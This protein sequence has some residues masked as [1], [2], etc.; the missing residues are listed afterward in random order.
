MADKLPKEAVRL[1]S[2]EA[3]NLT[4]LRKRIRHLFLG[5][6]VGGALQILRYKK[7]MEELLTQ[8]FINVRIL[9]RKEGARRIPKGL[10]VPDSTELDVVASAI[11]AQSFSNA[12]ASAAITNSPF[13]TDSRIQRIV[14]TET[15]RAY[16]DVIREAATGYNLVRVWNSVLDAKTCKVCREM[17]GE[18]T[19][20][21]KPFKDGMEPGWIH[22]SCRCLSNLILK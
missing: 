16:S 11:A 19:L 21:G 5:T 13:A 2:A 8:E 7:E 17:D 20:P 9:G 3:K 6:V 18:E 10:Y 4:T 15:S 1:L 22:P 14:T 12:W